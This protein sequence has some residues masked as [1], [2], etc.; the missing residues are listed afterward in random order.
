MASVAGAAGTDPDSGENFP[1]GIMVDAI[2]AP[3]IAADP[4]AGG[5]ET[6]HTVTLDAGW[7]NSG[8][9]VCSYKLLPNKMVAVVISANHAAFS[10][11]LNVNGSSALPVPY[12]PVTNQRMAAYTN[13][14]ACG[15]V[16]NTLGLLSSDN[17]P[18]GS[19][20]L[21]G[22]GIFPLDI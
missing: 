15:L 3:T 9:P 4:I 7:T 16:L 2:N 8:G 21:R 11:A 18:S 20:Y 10:G 14:G 12:R 1:A 6:W 13:T 19:G 5:P 22:T 17:A